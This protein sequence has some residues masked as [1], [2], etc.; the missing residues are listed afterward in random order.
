MPKC[1]VPDTILVFIANAYPH[2]HTR[3]RMGVGEMVR[4]CVMKGQLRRLKRERESGEVP[5]VGLR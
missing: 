5:V 2:T 4:R 1:G 3:S